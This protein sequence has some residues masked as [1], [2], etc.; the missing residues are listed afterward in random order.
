MIIFFIVCLIVGIVL[1]LSSQWNIDSQVKMSMAPQD[2]E[3]INQELDTREEVGVLFLLI[4]AV[5]LIILLN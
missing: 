5:I 3:R 1:L 4:A 2:I